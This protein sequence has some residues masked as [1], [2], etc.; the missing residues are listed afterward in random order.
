MLTRIESPYSEVHGLPN[1]VKLRVKLL[2]WWDPILGGNKFY[3]LKYNLLRAKELG[4][5]HLVTT[6]GCYSNHLAATARAGKRFGFKTTGIVRGEAISNL[7]LQRASKDGMQLVFVSRELYRKRN[8]PMFDTKVLGTI[9]DWYFIPEGG[10]NADGVL[11]CGEIL[12]EQD[13][14]FDHVAVCCGTGTTALGLLNTLLPNQ[15]LLAF[16][17]MKG[18]SSLNMLLG[19]SEKVTVIHDYHFGGYAKSDDVLDQFCIGFTIKYG[20]Q[21]EPVYTGKMFFGLLKLIENGQIKPGASV[22]ALH[23]GG[24]QYLRDTPF[25]G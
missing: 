25:V 14:R 9:R 2:C 1:R 10:S 11:G 12:E 15:Q 17:V 21:I 4:L 8:E 13:K 16:S 7:T 22:L 5:N 18:N 20:I 23:T 24:L 6:G 19:Q 3:K